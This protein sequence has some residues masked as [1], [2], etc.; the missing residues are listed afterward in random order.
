MRSFHCICALLMTAALAAPASAQQPAASPD[1]AGYTI[2]VR[3]LPVG[4]EQIALTRNAEGWTILSSGRIGVPI[5]VIARRVEVR[6]TQDW[7]PRDMTIDPS[8]RFLLV[9]N[10]DSDVISIFAIDPES[11]ALAPTGRDIA[12]GTPMCVKFARVA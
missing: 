3:A 7:R 8:G 10:Q 4:N 2:F 1:S 12:I 9:C 5:D 11:G 6:Y